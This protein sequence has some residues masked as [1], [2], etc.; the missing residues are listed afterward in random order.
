[1][2]PGSVRASEIGSIDDE[3]QLPAP[4]AMRSCRPAANRTGAAMPCFHR[5][6][7]LHRA[8]FHREIEPFNILRVQLYVWFDDGAECKLPGNNSIRSRGRFGM[9][10][11]PATLVSAE[12]VTFVSTLVASTFTPRMTLFPESVTLPIR[13][14]VGPAIARLAAL[15]TN[16]SAASSLKYRIFPCFFAERRNP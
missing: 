6:A 12:E 16:S 7:L 14:A 4:R 8:Q 13:V 11:S 10:Y 3:R 1:M 2:T 9:E 15:N 5:D